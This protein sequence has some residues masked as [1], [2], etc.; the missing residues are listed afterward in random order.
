MKLLSL[1]VRH[2]L[3]IVHVTSQ[4]MLILRVSVIKD[5]KLVNVYHSSVLCLD[6]LAFLYFFSLLFLVLFLFCLVKNFENF[7]LYYHSFV[8]KFKTAFAI[9]C[10]TIWLIYKHTTYSPILQYT[11]KLIYEMLKLNFLENFTFLSLQYSDNVLISVNYQ[12]F[13]NIPLKLSKK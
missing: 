7:C 4:M 2:K 1:F 5:A 12:V 3:F 9:W 8:S 10:F 11:D 13:Y 6:F